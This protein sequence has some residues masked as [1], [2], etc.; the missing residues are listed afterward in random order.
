M[1][2]DF[3][4]G[5]E[6]SKIGQGV[7]SLAKI[8]HPT[9]LVFSQKNIAIFFHIFVSQFFLTKIIFSETNLPQC[10]LCVPIR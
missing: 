2:S 7:G 3:F 1:M 4:W 9:I 8:G 6:S 5:G 10:E